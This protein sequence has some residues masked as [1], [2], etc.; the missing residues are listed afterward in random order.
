MPV[1]PR[2]C[3]TFTSGCTERGGGGGEARS[4]PPSGMQ[5]YSLAARARRRRRPSPLHRLSHTSHQCRMTI[6][7]SGRAQN[8]DGNYNAA[9]ADIA[10]CS[11]RFL[12]LICGPLFD[13]FCNLTLEWTHEIRR[14][15]SCPSLTASQSQSQ[16]EEKKNEVVI[17]FRRGVTCI[18]GNVIC[19]TLVKTCTKLSGR[20]EIVA[21]P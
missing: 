6:S 3:D 10:L 14:P 8:V 1:T 21:A 19:W 18:Q 15:I 2:H 4:A 17:N 13:Q 20:V 11:S 7:Q 12:P 9:R 16:G 5:A